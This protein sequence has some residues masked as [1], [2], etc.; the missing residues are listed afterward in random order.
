[1]LLVSDLIPVVWVAM[2]EDWFYTAW[3]CELAIGFYLA[4]ADCAGWMSESV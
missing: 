1:M 3:A 2:S 4:S